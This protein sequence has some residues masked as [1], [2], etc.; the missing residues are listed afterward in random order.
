VNLTRI[1]LTVR[2][3][4]TR[5]AV[6]AFCV[7]CSQC[8]GTTP[9][10]PSNPG[11]TPVPP[12]TP[13]PTPNPPPIFAPQTFSGAGD[14]AICGSGQQDATAKLLD[15]LGGLIFTLGDNAYM[16]GTAR[17]YRECYDPSWG[18]LKGRT[19]P[20]PGNHE[21]VTPGASGYFDYF[22][23]Q[24]GT[25]GLGF[26]SFDLG[27]WHIVSLNSEAAA[28]TGSPQFAWL[29][30][31]LQ[32]NTMNCTLAYWHK[33]LFT[34]GPNGENPHMRPIFR[35]L[36]EYG[37]DVVLNGHDHVYERF[38][39]QDPDGRFDRERGIVEFIVG[40]GG[41]PLYPFLAARP[42]SEKRISDSHGILKLTLSMNAYQ[43]EFIPV[44]GARS[45][46]FGNGT[47]H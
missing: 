12:T 46:D 9:S 41:V 36:Y 38:A 23:M 18:R 5:V 1:G 26:Y 10:G 25:S 24:A 32:A 30:D 19:R 40:T 17:Q 47:C 3:L 31:D 45:T 42:N 16:E 21:Y 13:T 20:T 28:S 7:A 11:P 14:I 4:T 2:T 22:G 27:A 44:P 43:Y 29:Q 35:L 37:A 34:S 8:A 15:S 39:P 6:V 33:P